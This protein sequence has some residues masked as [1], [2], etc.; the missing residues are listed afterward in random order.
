MPGSR[1]PL[2]LLGHGI[3]PNRGGV[4]GR[5]DR[6]AL[7]CSPITFAPGWQGLA[8]RSASASPAEFVM[9]SPLEE[10]GFELAVPPRNEKL[11]AATP[12]KHCRFGPKS[13]SGSA[14]RTAVSVERGGVGEPPIVHSRAVIFTASGNRPARGVSFRPA[15]HVCASPWRRFM[16]RNVSPIERR[17]ARAER[18]PQPNHLNP[19]PSASSKCSICSL[20]EKEGGR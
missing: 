6:A 8:G 16:A 11:W 17:T 15:D 14:F 7:S 2:L 5:F 10:D 19:L 20:F 1:P 3:T 13:V 18:L 12:G 4:V 9:D